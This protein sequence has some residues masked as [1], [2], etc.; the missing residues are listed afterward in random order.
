M[1]VVLFG[2]AQDPYV[3]T[4]YGFVVE[5]PY[6]TGFALI[7]DVP[8]SM[9]N[10]IRVITTS[11][12]DNQWV[13][14]MTTPEPLNVSIAII[15]EVPTTLVIEKMI[16]IIVAAPESTVPDTPDVQIPPPTQSVGGTT[17]RPIVLDH[18]EGT[19]EYCDYAVYFNNTLIT[20]DVLDGLTINRNLDTVFD[21]IT[22]RTHST[23]VT[24]ALANYDDNALFAENS[25]IVVIGT[26]IYSFIVEDRQKAQYG[27]MEVWG[28]SSAALYDKPYHKELTIVAEEQ[29]S[30]G[31]IIVATGAGKVV[32]WEVHSWTIPKNASFYGTPIDILMR[33][34]ETVGAVVRNT[35]DGGLVVKYPFVSPGKMD[36]YTPFA[37]FSGDNLFRIGESAEKG[38]GY[39]RVEVIG[40]QDQDITPIIKRSI[41]QE[42]RQIIT[43]D[44][45]N[46]MIGDT[47]DIVVFLP[48]YDP[49]A[50]TGYDLNV[51]GGPNRVMPWS[52]QYIEVQE[53]VGVD[54]GVG[55]TSVPVRHIMGFQSFGG[56]PGSAIMIAPNATEFRTSNQSFTGSGLLR[57][58][59]YGIGYRVIGMP[60][61]D[62]TGIAAEYRPSPQVD[63][64]ITRSAD[65]RSDAPPIVDD[66]ITD[67]KVAKMRGLRFFIDEGYNTYSV[68]VQ[69][70]YTQGLGDGDLVS[71]NEADI[72]VR[73]NYIVK[74]LVISLNGPQY[75]MEGTL[76]RWS[77]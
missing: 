69:F 8:Y 18:P 9:T 16:S 75:I 37:D 2:K 21:E 72:G 11:E 77:G 39:N 51:T 54:N 67:E 44:A 1:P 12:F 70:P 42:G 35:A 19:F 61:V 74:D 34:A 55:S 31:S 57:Y 15:C 60:D 7:T 49:E 71:V 62:E 53:V 13:I 68:P 27:I 26:D 17:E 47:V 20:H 38:N 22:L 48:Y 36:S 25:I 46:P 65:T 24:E 63:V 76:V 50:S 3:Y 59:A 14:R 28:R 45:E 66:L 10:A 58:M 5:T 41:I 33:L 52:V 23:V 6:E 73:G 30:T 43:D 29:T 40:H 56:N 4:H 32:S 64:F